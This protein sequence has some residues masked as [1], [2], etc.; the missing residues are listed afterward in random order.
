[1]AAVGE[2]HNAVARAARAMFPAALLAHAK[3]GD[4][5]EASA[6]DWLVALLRALRPAQTPGPASRPAR[7]ML[8]PASPTLSGATQPPLP[9]A[10]PEH[11]PQPAESPSTQPPAGSAPSPS[12]SGERPAA[13]R[14]AKASASWHQDDTLVQPK[15]PLPDPEDG[16]EARVP[17]EQIMPG[18]L[19]ASAQPRAWRQPGNTLP[20]GE[21]VRTACTGDLPAQPAESTRLRPPPADGPGLYAP[22]SGRA[23]P[24]SVEVT[25]RAADDLAAALAES[26][27]ITRAIYRTLARVISDR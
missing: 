6:P 10:A 7:A 3:K 25:L 24:V 20:A 18:S 13:V 12:A 15:A 21:Q 26:D 4:R 2:Y 1:M 19:P 16:Q 8:P 14:A 22:A 5:Q 27:E 17:Q 9:L 23:R 11:P